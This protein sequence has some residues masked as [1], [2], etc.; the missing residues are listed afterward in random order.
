MLAR[1][2]SSIKIS[3][4]PKPLK[5]TM[6]QSSMLGR[7]LT[8]TSHLPSTYLRAILALIGLAAG[9]W[10]SEPTLCAQ[11]SAPSYAPD[12]PIEGSIE[13]VGSTLMQPIAALWMDE[14]SKIHPELK[15]TIDCQGSE[16]SFKKVANPTAVVGLLS[17]EVTS[18]ELA[19][20][21]TDTKNRIVAISVGYDVISIIVN[22]KNPLQALAWDAKLGSPLSLGGEKSLTTWGD[23]GVEGE[24]ADKALNFVVIGKNHGLRTV[25]ESVL[26]IQGKPD[27]KLIEKESQ[28]EIVETV[29]A[30]PAAIAVVSS[31]RI[32]K[33]SVR[34][35]PIALDASRIIS[36]TNPQAVDLGYPLL[37][38]L[39]V[40]ARL[41][42]SGKLAPQIEE[43][44]R[45]VLSN[46]GQDSLVKDGFVPLDR[47]DIY[48]QQ[49]L[50]GWEI[51]K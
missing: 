36:S 7:H 28:L 42:E 45:F 22:P 27:V 26:A 46:Q 32:T 51:L 25:S 13:I 10:A 24:L 31:T 21:N 50:L 23:L 18:E 38:K 30:D 12:K 48:A 16:E 17:R 19:S 40:V 1:I 8:S 15:S 9:F 35:L 20:L 2:V 29:A 49:E 43:F 41:D 34:P 5:H 47:S 14:F 33:D 37:R 39:T 6:S 3:A 11:D 44:V 4:N